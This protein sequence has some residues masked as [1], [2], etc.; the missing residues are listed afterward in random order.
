MIVLFYVWR[1]DST[2]PPGLNGCRLEHGMV[3][4]TDVLTAVGPGCARRRGCSELLYSK[5]LC[6]AMN[7]PVRMLNQSLCRAASV[8]VRRCTH[9]F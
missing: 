9:Y 5:I 7:S 8:I 3:R 4:G 2:A 1:Y 6:L